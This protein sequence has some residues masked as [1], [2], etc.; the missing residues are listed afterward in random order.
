MK[1]LS[2]LWTAILTVSILSLNAHA[3]DISM[4][5]ERG[6]KPI[7]FDINSPWVPTGY[8][9]A[10]QAPHCQGTNLEARMLSTGPDVIAQ[11][12]LLKDYFRQCGSDLARNGKHGILDLRI[13]ARAEYNF[14][15]NPYAKQVKITINEQ[16][17]NGSSNQDIIRGLLALKPT[18]DKRPLVIIKCG[19]LC[20]L[21]DSSMFR[22][23]MMHGF[24]ESPFHL[25]VLNGNTSAEFVMDNRRISI[26]GLDEGKQIVQIAEW[27][28]NRSN[29]RNRISSVHVVGMSNGG[30]A[31]LFASAYNSYA[32]ERG[33]NRAIDSVAALCP[34][35][36]LEDSINYLFDRSLAKGVFYDSLLDTVKEVESYLPNLRRHL[37]TNNPPR[38]KAM[39]T[40]VVAASVDHYSTLTAEWYYAPFGRNRI[41]SLSDMWRANSFTQFKDLIDTPTLVWSPKNDGIVSYNANGKRLKDA[42]STGNFNPNLMILATNKGN[43]CGLST[44]Y[45]WDTVSSLMRGFVISHSPEL[46]RKRSLQVE[47][48]NIPAVSL[49]SH[50]KHVS[51]EWIIHA[52]NDFLSLKYKVWDKWG[53]NGGGND[54]ATS[55]FDADQRN[56]FSVKKVKVRFS[57]LPQIA[58]LT[59]PRSRTEAQMITRWMNANVRVLDANGSALTDSVQPAA[60]VEW[61]TY[62]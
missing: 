18:R 62:D 61:P 46:L 51:Q 38:G 45:G 43:H 37:N 21:S 30:Q 55:P 36:E 7:N 19:L 15:Q 59:V 47:R 31:A 20:S 9:W 10:T 27:L 33:A 40:A 48:A 1:R 4:V 32:R 39:P 22:N 50:E 53:N 34:V 16:Y 58:N 13:L 24:D 49:S 60:L 2:T 6:P 11:R 54:C 57:D 25:L 56:C 17:R 5:E 35:V 28:R 52:G 29:L 14:L 42:Q 26:G 23:V 8:Y 3:A 41:N 44:A 12:R